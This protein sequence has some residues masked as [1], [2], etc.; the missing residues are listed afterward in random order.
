MG[1]D[2]CER[3]MQRGWSVPW[4]TVSDRAPWTVERVPETDSHPFGWI[5]SDKRSAYEIADALNVREHEARALAARLAE[6]VKNT[7]TLRET[8]TALGERVKTLTAERDDARRRFC[9][10]LLEN[11]EI[12]RRVD[13]R[14]VLCTTHDDVAEI[15]GWTFTPESGG[16]E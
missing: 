7:Y 2:Y 6:P 11:G 14:N 5:L 8:V 9:Q 16:I 10:T 3:A 4:W 12:W 15:M 1:V 13:G